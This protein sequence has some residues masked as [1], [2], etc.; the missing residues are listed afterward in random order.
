MLNIIPIYTPGETV[1]FYHNVSYTCSHDGLWFEHDRDMT[2][3]EVMCLPD[4]SWDV[5]DEWP[6]CV[7]G[8]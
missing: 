8:K 2:S 3:F 5:P 6:F 4:G 1:E 7:N